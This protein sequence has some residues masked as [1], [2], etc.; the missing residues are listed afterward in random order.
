MAEVHDGYAGKVQR[1]QQVDV[2][3]LFGGDLYFRH[4]VSANGDDPYSHTLHAFDW[5]RRDSPTCRTVSSV[6]A[7]SNQLPSS[8][9]PAHETALSMRP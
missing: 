2:Q 8:M 5:R 1:T 9:M 4:F 3:G 7:G 6:N